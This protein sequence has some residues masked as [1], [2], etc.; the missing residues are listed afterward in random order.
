MRCRDE[1]EVE[2][3]NDTFLDKVK[4]LLAGIEKFKFEAEDA[5]EKLVPT[6]TIKKKML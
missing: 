5:M 4:T 3:E 6:S 1:R 2:I